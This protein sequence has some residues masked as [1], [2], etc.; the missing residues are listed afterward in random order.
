M[1]EYR[2]FDTG[3]LAYRE[4]L[5]LR[6]AILRRPLGLAMET[7]EATEAIS[8]HFGVFE[9]GRLLGCV[10]AVP[11]GAPGRYQVRQMAIAEACQGQGL[12]R[13]LLA[14]LEATL[15]AEGATLLFLHARQTALAFYL[16]LGY[17]PIGPLFMEVTLPH[18]AMEKCLSKT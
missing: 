3:S 4:A 9:D 16:K 14:F 15:A 18:Q 6:D 10:L 13:G 2:E 1:A 11:E 12:G 8:R 7:E 5:L 17:Q